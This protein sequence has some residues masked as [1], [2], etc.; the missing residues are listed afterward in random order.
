MPILDGTGPKGTGPMTGHGKGSCVVPLNTT[1]E[2][3]GF[4]KNQEQDLQREL[5]QV[6]YRI[7]QLEKQPN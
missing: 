5:K 1:M 7:K 2:E 6:K 3:L 4:L